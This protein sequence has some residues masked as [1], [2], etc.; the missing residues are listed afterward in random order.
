[1]KAQELRIG[2]WVLSDADEMIVHDLCMLTGEYKA[3][4]LDYFFFF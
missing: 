2:N 3:K 4:L 1:M